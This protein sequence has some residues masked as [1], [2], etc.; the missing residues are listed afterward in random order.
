[1]STPLNR[2]PFNLELALSGATVVTR[3]GRLVTDIKI[4]NESAPKS[5]KEANDNDLEYEQGIEVT[6]HNSNFSDRYSYYH[7]GGSHKYGLDTD[8][9][10]FLH[11]D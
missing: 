1:M 11:L 8:A 7:N 9:D 6:I 4:I 2:Q 10:L 5:A 3:D